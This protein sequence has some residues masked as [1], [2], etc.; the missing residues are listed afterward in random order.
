MLKKLFS[1]LLLLVI[2]DLTACRI[3]G[4]VC[5]AKVYVQNSSSDNLKVEVVYNSTENN[6]CSSCTLSAGEHLLIGS[7]GDIGGSPFPQQFINSIKIYRNDSL[8]IS[9]DAPFD[10]MHQT[11]EKGEKKYDKNFTFTIISTDIN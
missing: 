9:S 4:E 5:V 3:D 2:S 6:F 1:G 10:N 8:K 7:K 11:F